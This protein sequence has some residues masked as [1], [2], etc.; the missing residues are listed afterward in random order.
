MLCYVMLCYVMLCYV[1]LCYVMLCY[2]VLCYVMVCYVMLCYVMLCYVMVNGT[3]NISEKA[4][5][6]HY[7]AV[8]R[9]KA[10]TPKYTVVTGQNGVTSN[11]TAFTNQKAATPCTY[12]LLVCCDD[13]S[14]LQSRKALSTYLSKQILSFDFCTVHIKY[15]Q[16]HTDLYACHVAP[17]LH[18][19]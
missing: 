15:S 12:V 1:M 10:V 6:P 17:L 8:R 11:N 7:T 3:H 13:S 4:V 16:I 5:T 9:Q 2:V 14:P 19:C 18:S